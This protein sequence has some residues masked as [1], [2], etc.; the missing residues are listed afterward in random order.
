MKTEEYL[1]KLTDQ[2]RCAKARAAIA[3]E[4][5][6]HIDEQKHA[7]MSVGMEAEEAEE[8]AVKEMGDPVEAGSLLDGIHRPRMAW[9]MI[10]LIAVL[11]I[12][13][14]IILYLLQRNF[15]DMTFVTGSPVHF[16]GWAIAG[17]AGMIGACY[18][19]YSRIGRWAK[20]IMLAAS[21]VL[22]VGIEHYGTSIN[23]A[24][25]WIYGYQVN[26][27]LLLFLFVPLYGAVLYQYRGEGKR[28]VVKGILW[29]AP[30]IMTALKIPSTATVLI[31]FLA[32]M[33][34]L[35]IAIYKNWFCVSR[36]AALGLL[37]LSAFLP[38]ILFCLHIFTSGP[39]YQRARLWDMV[40]AGAT[41][42]KNTIG[43][44]LSDSQ[45]IGSPNG[46]TWQGG[47]ASGRKRLC[48]WLYCGLLW[49]SYRSGLCH[50]DDGL[51]PV[52]PETFVKTEESARNDHGMRMFFGTVLPA[53]GLYPY[54]YRHNA[55]RK[56]LLSIHYL[57]KIRD[58][59]DLCSSGASSEY[60]Q[61]PGRAS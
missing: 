30:A 51:V 39:P 2:I 57:W 61:I 29:M 10:G 49:D 37:W 16:G 43:Q 25:G 59:G 31:L 21:V 54:Q 22:L 9:G 45:L 23:G 50:I 35:S 19:D 24:I 15:S 32:F 46:G 60:L 4:M 58:A 6:G 44:I 3:E 14:F 38:A 40:H 55:D 27:K 41:V 8:A 18:L 17:F 36:K 5:R 42:E 11:S 20:E 33:A 13:G 48:A 53:A 47:A 52:F 56:R 26:V 34:V 28:A 12:A 1:K 7:Y